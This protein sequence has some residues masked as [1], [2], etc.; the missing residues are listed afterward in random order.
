MVLQERR[1]LLL[2]ISIL[3]SSWRHH[4]SSHLFS[5]FSIATTGLLPAFPRHWVVIV[6]HASIV[7]LVGFF[8]IMILGYVF[9][10]RPDHGGQN[11]RRYLRVSAIGICVEL[12]LCAS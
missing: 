8:S 6:A 5:A 2:P 1:H 12:R 4:S 7:V 10:Q 9:P 3:A 11:L